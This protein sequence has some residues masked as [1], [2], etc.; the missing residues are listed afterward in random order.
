MY[1]SSIILP[2]TKSTLAITYD[3]FYFEYMCIAMHVAIC[4]SMDGWM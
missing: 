1:P 2:I 3:C 4:V